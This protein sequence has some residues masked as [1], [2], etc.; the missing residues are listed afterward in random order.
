M[1]LYKT[2][3]YIKLKPMRPAPLVLT[4]N[5]RP[6]HH[7]VKELPHS[8][9]VPRSWRKTGGRMAREGEVGIEGEGE[10]R[11]VRG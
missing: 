2:F 7:G 6:H 8:Q 5:V 10:G 4:A 11:S 1:P 3:K 9:A